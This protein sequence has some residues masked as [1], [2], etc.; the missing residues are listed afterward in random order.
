MAAVFSIGEHGSRFV[1]RV[2]GQRIAFG[3]RAL[4]GEKLRLFPRFPG[5]ER[6]RQIDWETDAETLVDVHTDH[7][8]TRAARKVGAVLPERA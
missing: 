3:D 8:D 6:F 7:N 2:I 4:F 1:Q 5:F